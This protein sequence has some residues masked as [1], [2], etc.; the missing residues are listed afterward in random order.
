MITKG[1]TAAEIIAAQ[2]ELDSH[3]T[4][5]QFKIGD[6]ARWD[7]DK[8]TFEFAGQEYELTSFAL[9]QLLKKLKIPYPYFMNCSPELRDKEIREALLDANKKTEYVFK[10]FVENDAAVPKIFGI[11]PPQYYPGYTSNVFQRAADIIPGNLEASESEQ[12][13]DFSRIRFLAKDTSFIE[14]DEIVPGIDLWYSEVGRKPFLLQSVMF[15]KVCSNG[16]MLP[17]SSSPC[18]KIPMTR[19]KEEQFSA[20]L[21][22]LKESILEKQRPFAETLEKLKTVE[23]PN[24]VE[25]DEDAAKI[26][27]AKELVLP[28]RALQADYG[29]LVTHQYISDNNFTMNGIVNAVTRVARDIESSEKL[30]LEESA[31]RFTSKI[32]AL[33]EDHRSHNQEMEYSVANFRRLFKRHA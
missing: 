14:V 16:L 20:M 8:L 19:F 22:T 10:V 33:E 15:R 24:S 23:L 27:A 12:H 6:M 4:Y 7:S 5:F 18:G 25:S 26:T 9:K 17:E 32:F 29:D 28:S 21:S 13:L 30:L 2:Q 3:K 31:G 11:V 1:K